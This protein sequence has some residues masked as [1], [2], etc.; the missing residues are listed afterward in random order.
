MTSGRSLAGLIVERGGDCAARPSAA[1]D[2]V[3]AARIARVHAGEATT[4]S[5]EEVER[6][7]RDE[8][9]F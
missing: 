6:T 7:V 5:M 3:E 2:R 8:L 9:D 1:V 4:L